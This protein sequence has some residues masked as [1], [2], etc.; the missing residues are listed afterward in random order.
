MKSRKWSSVVVITL[1]AL[2]MPVGMAAQDIPSQDH[3]SKHHQ[4]K[5]KDLGTLGGP[6][7][8]IFGLTRPLNNRG[9]VTGCSDTSTL[10][11]NNPKNPYFSQPNYPNGLDPY[12]Q[13]AF[14]WKD[15]VLNDLALLPGGT[16]SCTQWINERGMIA[17]GATTG[18]IDPLTGYPEV[19]AVLW[20]N[21]TIRNLGTLGGNESVA[22]GLNNHGQVVGFALNT[23]PDPFTNVFAFGTTQAHAFQWQDGVMHDLGTLGGP[24]SIAWFANERGQIAGQSFTNSS[25]NGM[26]G[27]PTM[28]PFLWVPCDRDYWESDECASDTES[29]TTRKA[30]CWI[31]ALSEARSASRTIS[32]T[33]ARWSVNRTWQE[34]RL[35]IHS[36]GIRRRAS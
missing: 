27:V 1:F 5:L 8:I 14:Q 25:P 24:D 30:K 31:S 10:D 11:P 15:G 21:G 20:K 22:F 35:T 9:V 32:T 33:E 36:C 29:A 2:A 26:T 17:G 16:S 7:S 6:Q 13:H 34:T 4:F 12:I 19:N 28:D 18:I 3:K 23:I